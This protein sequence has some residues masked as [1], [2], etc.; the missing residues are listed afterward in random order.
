MKTWCWSENFYP[1]AVI[2][3]TLLHEFDFSLPGI[4]HLKLYT[5]YPNDF[6][7]S[8]DAFETEIHV[9]GYPSVDLGP[10][11]EISAMEYLLDA[12]PGHAGYLWRDG[13]TGQTY[14]VDVP[15]QEM[16][17]V[18]VTRPLRLLRLRFGINHP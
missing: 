1:G 14:A 10:D 13:S 17:S 11:R 4:Y 2:E 18:E 5:A 7:A 3:F 9:Y 6:D 15:G 12:G 16:Y 8:N